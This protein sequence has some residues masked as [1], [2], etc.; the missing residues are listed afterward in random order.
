MLIVKKMKRIF[1]AQMKIDPI[2]LI[3]K[4]I[5]IIVQGCTKKCNLTINGNV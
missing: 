4:K 5:I 2:V 3:K 1:L